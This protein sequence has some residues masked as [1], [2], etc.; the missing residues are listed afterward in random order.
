MLLAYPDSKVHVA[1]MGPTWV[2]SAPGGPHVGP[3]DLAIRV[4]LLEYSGSNTWSPTS[5]FPENLNVSS[6]VKQLHV[7]ISV[8]KKRVLCNVY[9]YII[10]WYIRLWHD[11]MACRAVPI[12][13]TPIYQRH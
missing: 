8:W 4:I 10:L 7:H 3:M 13:S 12:I 6:I 5:H 9:A 11:S 2:L 1:N